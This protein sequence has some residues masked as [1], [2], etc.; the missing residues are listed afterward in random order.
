M[1]ILVLLFHFN[2]NTKIHSFC[3]Y[4]WKAARCETTTLPHN[5]IQCDLYS[6]SPFCIHLLLTGSYVSCFICWCCWWDVCASLSE[7][8]DCT[9]AET[10]VLIGGLKSLQCSLSSVKVISAHKMECSLV[11]FINRADRPGPENQMKYCIEVLL[12]VALLK[13]Q[14]LVL[15]YSPCLLFAWITISIWCLW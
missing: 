2:V 9:R 3:V 5:A 8:W 10:R 13:S 4:S 11:F 15:S 7:T 14:R 6:K 1:C 12:P